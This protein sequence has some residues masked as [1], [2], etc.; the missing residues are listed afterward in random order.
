MTL[1][2]PTYQAEQA[3]LHSERDDYGVASVQFAPIVSSLISRLEVDTV[4]DYGCGKG[5]LATALE[6]KRTIEIEMY[7]PAVPR[8]MDAPGPAELVVCIDV[9]EHIEPE[10]LDNVLDHIKQLAREYVFLTIHTGP[11]VKVLSDGRN[12]HLIQQGARWWLPKLLDRWGLMEAKT[13]GHGIIF[14]GRVKV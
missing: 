3:R 14:I 9:L 12:A 7:D 13:V 6:P 4:L 8:F 1:I 10:L 5:R 11:A 2:T